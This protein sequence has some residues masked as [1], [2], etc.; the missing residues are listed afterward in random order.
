MAASIK[1]SLERRVAVASIGIVRAI[2]AEIR[3]AGASVQLTVPQFSM[4]GLLEESDLSVGEVARTLHVAMPTVTQST[5][6]LAAKGLLERYT[7]DRDRR[8]VKLHITPQ[9]QRLLHE[10]YRAVEGYLA[11][12]LHSW[13]PQRRD[14]LARWMD[15]LMGQCAMAALEREG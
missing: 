13:P 7:D 5:D 11:H 9:G 4:L 14:A 3:R 15:E 10:C 12:L 6:S 1:P 8:Q 2:A